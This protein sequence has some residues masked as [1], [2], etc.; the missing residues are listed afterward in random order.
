MKKPLLFLVL[1][2]LS[3]P[4]LVY[5]ASIFGQLYYPFTRLYTVNTKYFDIIYSKRSEE[6]AAYLSTF[7]DETYDR[8]N[9]LMKAKVNGRIAV[10]LSSDAQLEN[11]FSMPFPYTHIVLADYQAHSFVNHKEYIKDLFLHELTHAVSLNVK[12]DF[13]N[14]LCVMFGNYLN[15]N[16]SMPEFMIEGVTVSFESLDGYGRV[17]DPLAAHM[18]RQ[19][20]LEGRFKSPSQATGAYDLYPFGEIYYHYGGFFSA[21][22]QKKYGME[23]YDRLWQENGGAFPY[24]LPPVFGNVYPTN[25][26]DEW[27]MFR[28]SM[29]YTLPVETNLQYLEPGCV[30]KRMSGIEYPVVSGD[31]I[32]YSDSM[33]LDVK[34]YDTKTKRLETLF[35]GN[36]ELGM[37]PDGKTLLAVSASLADGVLERVTRFFD[38]ERKT[39]LDRK[40]VGLG[41]A[42][43]FGE[44]VIGIR[45]RGHKTDVVLVAKDNSETVLL[46]G[47][48]TVSYYHPLQLD[49]NRVVLLMT[50]NGTRRVAMLDIRDSSLSVLEVSGGW[51]AAF[52]VSLGVHGKKVL[53]S[54]NDDFSF[55]KAAVLDGDT[56]YLQTN[57]VSGGVFDPVLVDENVYYVGRF[58]DGRLLLKYPATLAQWNGVRV[59]TS[60][61][62]VPGIKQDDPSDYP[63]LKPSEY[64][65]LPYLLPHFFI[66]FATFGQDNVPDSVGIYSLMYD[67]LYDNNITLITTYNYFKNLL[68]LNVDWKNTSFPI[69]LHAAAMDT[70]T[71]IAGLPGYLRQT[72]GLIDLSYTFHYIPTYHYLTVGGKISDFLGSFDN[73]RSTAYAWDY[74]LSLPVWELYFNFS[75]AAAKYR[76]YDYKG[77]SIAGYYDYNLNNRIYKTELGASFYPSFLPLVIR[78]NAAYSFWKV[79]SPGSYSVSFGSHHYPAFKEYASLTNASDYYVNAE[80]KFPLFD[81]EIQQGLWLLPLYF[82]RFYMTAGYRSALFEAGYFQSLFTRVVLVT[83]PLYGGYVPT[84]SLYFELYYRINR[85]DLGYE[86]NYNIDF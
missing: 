35:D 9:S 37:S 13:F 70:V 20:I 58:S 38:L 6:T 52:P 60:W 46:K 63:A 2:F 24:L 80:V 12:S 22:L 69:N 50:D 17:N 57:N 18:V 47:T 54:Y 74:T 31:R 34:S 72:G 21:Y 76:F 44:D 75:T 23:K 42:A 62:R 71:Y 86:L 67:P 39:F 55:Y 56:L 30:M 65:A 4:V 32:I 33:D 77:F 41:S 1:L 84:V 61:K 53:F 48:E 73:G 8:L 83:S 66:P 78:L 79:F 27:G 3:V 85:N 11:G 7:A 16:Y 64:N 14:V 28:E 26:F 51:K 40:L 43:F 10:V 15:P 81:L 19:D 68:N 45:S 36:C 59:K 29:R 5:S 82:N 49:S 25:F